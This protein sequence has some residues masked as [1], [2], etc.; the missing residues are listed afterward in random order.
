M[1]RLTVSDLVDAA[2]A[3]TLYSRDELVS[4]CRRRAVVRV[5]QAIFYLA[6]QQGHS[7]PAI[8]QRLGRDHSTVIHGC[9][10]AAAVMRDDPYYVDTVHAIQKAAR[11][12]QDKRCATFLATTPRMLA[13]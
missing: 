10:M 2:A 1:S 11:A 8:G 6:R 5:R 12:I 4:P 13:A 3:V 9:Q 7:F